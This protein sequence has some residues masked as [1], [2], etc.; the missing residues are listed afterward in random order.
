MTFVTDDLFDDEEEAPKKKSM[1][2]AAAP[3]Q[4]YL[5]KSQKQGQG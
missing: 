2:E 1:K 3:K 5:G 4:K